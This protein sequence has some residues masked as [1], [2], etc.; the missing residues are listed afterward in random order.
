MFELEVYWVLSVLRFVTVL[1]FES[2]IL[3]KL[4]VIEAMYVIYCQRMSCILI[5]RAY[6]SL[7]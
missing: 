6:N 5:M 7:F 4:L 2:V 3:N 1:L